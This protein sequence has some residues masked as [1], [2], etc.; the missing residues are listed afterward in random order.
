[1][2]STSGTEIMYPSVIVTQFPYIVRGTE[3]LTRESFIHLTA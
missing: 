3:C 1:M 2:T